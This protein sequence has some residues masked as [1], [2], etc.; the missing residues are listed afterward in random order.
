[1]SRGGKIEIN[2]FFHHF[3]PQRLRFGE[4]YQKKISICSI[5]DY[6]ALTSMIGPHCVAGGVINFDKE[7]NWGILYRPKFRKNEE[8]PC[9]DYHWGLVADRVQFDDNHNADGI[10]DDL[11]TNSAH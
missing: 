8:I 11:N 9:L 4:M 5:L 1:M 7:A 6:N 3:E 10:V 2:C